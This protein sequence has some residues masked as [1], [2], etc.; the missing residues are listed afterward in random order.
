[1]GIAGGFARNT[2]HDGYFFDHPDE[3]IAGAIPPP[4]FNL[5]N[6][7]AVARHVRSLVLEEARLD[8]PSD[9]TTLLG[10]EGQLLEPNVSNLVKRIAAAREVAGARACHIFGYMRDVVP[11]L[12]RWLAEVVD[13]VSAMVRNAMAQR[14]RLIEDA[15]R[16]MREHGQRVRQSPREGEAEQGYRWLARRLREDHKYAYLPRVLAEAGVLPGYAFPRDPGSLSLAYDPEP[17]F[18]RRLQ[19]Q[20]EYAPGQIVYAR[21]RRWR[22]RGLALNRPGA[23]GPGGGDHRFEFTECPSCGLAN[24]AR[25]ANQC[26]RCGGELGGP[27]RVAWDAGAFQAWPQEVEPEAEEDRDV[28]PYDI[29]VH[30]Q[31]NVAAEVYELGPWRLERRD[32]E[33]IWWINHGPRECGLDGGHGAP[34][35]GF[36]LCPT[37]GEVVPEPPAQAPQG[38]GRRG[39]RPNRDPRADRDEHAARCAGVPDHFAVGHQGPADTLR[40]VVPGIGAAGADGLAWAWSFAYAVVQGAIR[41][42]G[43]DEDDL[44]T[45]VL[46]RRTQEGEEVL[47][48][49]WVDSI[50]G[51]SGILREMAVGFPAVARAAL[52]HLEGHECPASCYR[53][54]RTY[55][56][57]RVHRLLNWRLTE[58]YLRA[59]STEG[60]RSLGFGAGAP[61][62]TE[63]PEWEE[64]RREGCGSP[65]ELRLLRAMREAGLPEPEKQYEVRDGARLITLADFAYP[66]RRL[67]IYVDTLAFH[68]SIRQRVHDNRQTNH[69]QN[70]GFRVF[71][72]LAREIP[73]AVGQIRVALTA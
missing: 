68:S 13:A 37:C 2:P 1:M 69:L 46:T 45:M 9:L 28:R 29:R 40:L 20:R 53:C 48:I 57:Q 3:V 19:A 27:S 25:G 12:G 64:A 10:E 59:A 54:L 52:H 66:D 11:D 30:P 65:Q 61:H 67:L 4:R 5:N 73:Q 6:V 23:T 42:F 31:R 39:P 33:T 49:V 56:N 71:R 50:L 34:A 16:R 21:G 44:D 24:P 51:G 15:V 43:L 72:F 70:M 58:P 8:F 60:V 38:R 36:R 18:A 17:I 62:V 63:G 55:R 35:T 22:V 32:Q 41:Y 26:A 7:E 47:E 14:G